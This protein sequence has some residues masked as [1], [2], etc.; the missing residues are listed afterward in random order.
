MIDR[1]ILLIPFGGPFKIQ[2]IWGNHISLIV[3]I[4]KEPYILVFLQKAFLILLILCSQ[5]ICL[6]IIYTCIEYPDMASIPI[7]MHN[8]IKTHVNHHV[9]SVVDTYCSHDVIFVHLYLAIEY[10]LLLR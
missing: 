7:I 9:G 1:T 5:V 6:L 3:L 2:I 4:I 8:F 10:I